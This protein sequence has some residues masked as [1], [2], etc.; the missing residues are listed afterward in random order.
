MI[1]IDI[2]FYQHTRKELILDQLIV[3]FV[4]R[5][6]IESNIKTACVCPQKLEKENIHFNPPS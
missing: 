2:V 3:R 1:C 5:G 6:Q 4:S